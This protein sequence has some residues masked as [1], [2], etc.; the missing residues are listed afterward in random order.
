ME[1]K[2][3]LSN[4]PNGIPI[5]KINL[6]G[7]HDSA[8]AFVSFAKLSRCQSMTVREQLDAGIRLLDIRLFHIG[9]KF[10]LVHSQADCFTAADKKKKLTFEDVLDACIGFLRKNPGETIVMS[11]NQNR[12]FRGPFERMFFKDFY[13]KYI[14]PYEEFWFTDNRVPALCECRGKI[15]FMR[16]CK[17]GRFFEGTGHCGLD[18]SFWKD[19]KAK[20]DMKPLTVRLSKSCSAE[21]QDKY[22]L[23]PDEKWRD[24]AEPFLSSCEPTDRRYC[25]HFLSTCGGSGIPE[26]NAEA[27]NRYFAEYEMP[28]KPVG[29]IFLDFPEE[30][31]IDKIYEANYTYYNIK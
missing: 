8:T 11:V 25:V 3:I 2:A 23:A 4:L 14:R 28:R 13:N 30:K 16:R 26:K 17:K 12:G 6:A 15:V 19:Q 24:C 1:N 18:F 20:S 10:Y 21:I 5:S 29:W 31:L 22:S 27:V 7:T 9:D